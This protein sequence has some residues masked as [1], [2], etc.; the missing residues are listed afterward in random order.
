MKR[1]AVYGVSVI[2]V[3]V[4]WQVVSARFFSPALFPGPLA[5][6]GK[7]LTLIEEGQLQKD[8][9]A[10]LGRVLSG[11]ALGSIIGVAGGFAIGSSGLVRNFLDPYVHFL[12]FITPIAWISPV[13]IWFGIGETSKVVLITYTTTFAVMLSTTAGVIGVPRNRLRAARSC[14]ASATQ[15]FLFVIVPSALNQVLVG[16]RLAMGYSFM[17]VVPAEMLAAQ[18]GLGYL[19]INSRLWLA[20]DAIFVGILTLGLIGLLMDTIFR[21][22]TSRV[23][24]RYTGA[25]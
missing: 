17:T 25:A 16:M 14:G 15:I 5:V 3:L 11:F 10:S 9:L 13:M 24:A 21:L 2:A 19:I 23:L 6:A 18:T 8:T 7:A 12:R 1:L 20:T 22:V 4:V